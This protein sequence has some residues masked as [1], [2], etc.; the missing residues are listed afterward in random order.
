[1]QL[2]KSKK[3][4]LRLWCSVS[5]IAV[6]SYLPTSRSQKDTLIFSNSELLQAKEVIFCKLTL[7]T[8]RP[9]FSAL[10]LLAQT[11]SA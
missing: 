8:F 11:E 3:Q 6:I 4:E 1:M 5:M 2:L 9:T 7:L 10:F